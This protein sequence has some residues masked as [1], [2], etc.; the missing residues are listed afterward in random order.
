[1]TP[2]E[3]KLWVRLRQLRGQGFHFRRQSPWDGYILDFVCVRRGL[4]VEVDGDQHGTDSGAARDLRRDG[5][6]TDQGFR[7][8]RFW[9]R[10]VDSN[11]DG[12]ID[13]I[14][15]ALQSTEGLTPPDPANAGPPSP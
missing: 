15:L 7:T 11:L 13:T 8:L 9:N 10:E 1:M 6:F 3:V 5:H 2:Q 14:F 12:V 4:I